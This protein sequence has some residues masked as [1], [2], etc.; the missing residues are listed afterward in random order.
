MLA[1]GPIRFVLENSTDLEEARV[2]VLRAFSCKF[3]RDEAAQKTGVFGAGSVYSNDRFKDAPFLAITKNF[4]VE[5]L[6]IE[7]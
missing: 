1:L 5:S 2:F 4:A 3:R 7:N 6:N